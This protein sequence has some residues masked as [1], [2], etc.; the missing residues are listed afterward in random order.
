[1]DAL[2]KEIVARGA[3]NG[4]VA[5]KA[6]SRDRGR[7]INAGKFAVAAAAGVGAMAGFGVM[8]VDITDLARTL[9][10]AAPVCPGLFWLFCSGESSF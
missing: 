8:A 5:E 7:L 6:V 10:D 2:A 3:P 9:P 4:V 1:M